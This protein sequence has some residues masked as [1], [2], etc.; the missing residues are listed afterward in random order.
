MNVQTHFHLMLQGN[1]LELMGMCSIPAVVLQ[2]SLMGHIC[3]IVTCLCSPFIVVDSYVHNIFKYL[4]IFKIWLRQIFIC[5]EIKTP[6]FNM[7]HNCVLMDLCGRIWMTKGGCWDFLINQ[8]QRL[9]KNKMHSKVTSYA[10]TACRDLFIYLFWA[11]SFGFFLVFFFFVLTFLI[12]PPI[13]KTPSSYLQ[14]WEKF[15]IL[16]LN[17]IINSFVWPKDQWWA[18]TINKQ[19]GCWATHEFNIDMVDPTG[20]LPQIKKNK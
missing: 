4:I 11:C 16:F 2:G 17:C 7:K 13:K 12:V 18:T 5:E 14:C 10:E 9:K 19:H 20:K 8:W 3:I 6:Q 1:K 15:Y